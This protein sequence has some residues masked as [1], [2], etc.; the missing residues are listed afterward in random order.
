MFE[1]G[2]WPRYSPHV[3]QW[4]RTRREKAERI[5]LS[6]GNGPCLVN[7]VLCWSAL[8]E[9]LKSPPFHSMSKL[10]PARRYQRCLSQLNICRRQ[11]SWE[12]VRVHSNAVSHIWQPVQKILCTHFEIRDAFR[13]SQELL[14]NL[15]TTTVHT[16]KINVID[17]IVSWS[18]HFIHL[19]FQDFAFWIWNFLTNLILKMSL[20]FK[21]WYFT[22][23]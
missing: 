11:T 18:I 21:C 3:F 16:N 5:H 15:K 20:F 10:S 12:I 1:S 23:A 6:L 13:N 22:V 2:K 17:F 8:F 19:Y 14:T 7:N 4:R 9:A